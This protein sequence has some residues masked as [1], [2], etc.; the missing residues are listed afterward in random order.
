MQVETIH[1]KWKEEQAQRMKQQR[2]LYEKIDEAQQLRMEM[3]EATMQIRY[4]PMPLIALL[5]L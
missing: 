5:M 3:L 4:A 1:S 2:A